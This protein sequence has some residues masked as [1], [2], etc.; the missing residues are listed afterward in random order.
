[1]CCLSLA[2]LA[3]Q[4]VQDSKYTLL[5]RQCKLV[6]TDKRYS[7][8]ADN[9]CTEFQ[10]VPAGVCHPDQINKVSLDYLLDRGVSWKMAVVVRSACPSDGETDVVRL[11]LQ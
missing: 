8:V 5:L 11:V 1:M 2:F 6:L 9:I 4:D 3:T 7:Y 10:H